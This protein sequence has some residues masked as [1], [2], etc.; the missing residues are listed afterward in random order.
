MRWSPSPSRSAGGWRSGWPIRLRSTACSPAG[1]NGPDRLRRRPSARSTSGWGSSRRRNM[2]DAQPIE[3]DQVM[4]GVAIAIP[5][6]HAKTLTHWRRLV[7]DP[8][9]DRV[10]PHVTLLPPTPVPAGAPAPGRVSPPVTLLPPPPVPAARLDEIQAHL[11]A[12]AAA[13]EPFVM[14]LAGT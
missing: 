8:A 1:P 10:F 13:H 9:A 7:G 3:P 4:L 6:P 11:A 2:T 12:A 14:H 5:Q